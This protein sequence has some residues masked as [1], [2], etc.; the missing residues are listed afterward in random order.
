[1]LNFKQVA[2]SVAILFIGFGGLS[3]WRALAWQSDDGLWREILKTNPQSA[4]AHAKLGLIALLD[5]KLP[6]AKKQI[7][8]AAK[9]DPQSPLAHLALGRLRQVESDDV[10]A[11]KEFE[12]ALKLAKDNRASSVIVAQCQAQVADALV[13]QGD[14][15]RVKELVDEATLVLGESSQLHYLMGMKLLNDKQYVLAINDLQQ[16]FIQDQRNTQFI[17]PLAAAYLGSRLPT[18][19]PQA[20]KLM[21]RAVQT[22]PTQQGLLLYARAAIELNRIDQAKDLIEQAAKMGGEDAQV[23]YLRYFVARAQKNEAQAQ[24]FKAKALSLDPKIETNVPVVAPE[25]IQKYLEDED[26]RSRA[27]KAPSAPATKAPAAAA[28]AAGTSAAPATT[29][30]ADATSS[31]PAPSTKA[32]TPASSQPVANPAKPA[33][34]P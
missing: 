24:A 34:N 14:Y 15:A 18:L 23:N 20:Y 6:E 11:F 17:E 31:A 26:R 7:D 19:I 5:K 1:L 9:L 10:E 3:N 12:T 4:R 25:H 16:G 8:E 13:R 21:E 29:K 30:P 32:A 27:P 2:A 28:P 22:F 33:A